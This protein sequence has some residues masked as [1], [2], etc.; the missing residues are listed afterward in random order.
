MGEAELE[1][2]G[3]IRETA[4]PRF[5]TDKTEEEISTCNVRVL[6]RDAVCKGNGRIRTIGMILQNSYDAIL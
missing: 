6:C 2:Q 5:L 3:G 4:T 1:R